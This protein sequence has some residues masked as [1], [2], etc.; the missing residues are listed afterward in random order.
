LT[1]KLFH[2]DSCP[3]Y[4]SSLFYYKYRRHH[5]V[6][7]TGQHRRQHYSQNQS[8]WPHY[9]PQSH[10]HHCPGCPLWPPPLSDIKLPC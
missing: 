9:H 1:P 4:H 8:Y 7:Q 2:L 3:L 5:Q 6:N 10:H